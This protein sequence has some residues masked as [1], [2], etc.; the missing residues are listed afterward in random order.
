M[1]RRCWPVRAQALGQPVATVAGPP[2]GRTRGLPAWPAC[3]H[4]AGLRNAV[5]RT[6][7]G[8]PTPV[9]ARPPGC[10]AAGQADLVVGSVDGHWPL[11]L[12]PVAKLVRE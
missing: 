12:K 7:H 9:R 2:V 4:A 11:I 6:A 5:L 10:L 3:F 1:G 8:P